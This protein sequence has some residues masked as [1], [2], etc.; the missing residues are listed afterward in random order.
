MTKPPKRK[1]NQPQ[2]KKKAPI[3]QSVSKF[4]EDYGFAKVTIYKM[5]Q[6][7]TIP[8][9]RHGVERHGIKLNPAQVLEALTQPAVSETT[10]QP[11][12]GG[13]SND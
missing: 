6:A 1:K 11:T 12:T 9:V 13:G 10:K 4:C 3:L 2:D 7:K 5:I 8:V